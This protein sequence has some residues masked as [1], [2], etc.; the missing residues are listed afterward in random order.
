VDENYV[1]TMGDVGEEELERLKG[2]DN[3]IVHWIPY[4][5]SM[6]TKS[7]ASRTLES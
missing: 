5:E 4:Y 3:G 2:M 6:T 7:Q 1:M